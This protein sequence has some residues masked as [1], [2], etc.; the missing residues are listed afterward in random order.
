VLAAIA[1]YTG[2]NPKSSRILKGFNQNTCRIAGEIDPASLFPYPDKVRSFLLLLATILLGAT[3]LIAR[4]DQAQKDAAYRQLFASV[5]DQW[6]SNHDGLL[7]LKELNAAIENPAV[8]G[9]DAAIAVF[10]HRHLQVEKEGQKGLTQD[11]VLALAADPPTQKKIFGNSWHI[12]AINHSLFAPEDPNLATFHQGGIGDCYLLAVIGTFVF[13][14]PQSVRAMIQA[15]TN[16]DFQIQFGN[17]R[18]VNVPPLTDAE[19]IMG[20]SEGRN[21]G[22]WLSVLEKAYAQIDLE[23]KERKTGT[24]NDADEAVMTD[25]IGHGGYYAPVITLLTGHRATGAPLARWVKQDPQGGLERAHELIAANTS[26]NKSKPLPR[27]FAHGHVYGLLGY[28][29][30]ART[31]MVFNPWGNGFKPKGPPGPVNGYPTNHGIFQMPLADF[32]QV[33]GGFT[34]ETDRPAMVNQVAGR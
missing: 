24:T 6:D 27:G 25:F 1:A 20:A 22:V 34:Y 12:E 28:D 14:H 26:G 32:V 17:G 4:A 13:Q 15:Q 7:D 23:N 21:H 3:T 18:D 19:L 8:R 30:V 31:V 33:F 10:L 29:P 16:G 9:S 2:C 5:F 11:E